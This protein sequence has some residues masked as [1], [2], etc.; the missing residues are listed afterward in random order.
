MAVQEPLKQS[1]A[2][3]DRS[4]RETKASHIVRLLEN[5]VG[6]LDGKDLLEIGTGSGIIASALAKRVRSFLSVDVNDERQVLDFEF[7]R[8]ETERLPNPSE[9]FD[10]VVSNHVI[11]HVDDQQLHLGEVARV[12]RPGGVC[13]LATPNRWRLVEPHF[14]LPFLSW[15]PPRLRDPYVR[16]TR[17]G[18]WFDVQP[19]TWGRI[20]RL[21]GTAGLACTDLA[22]DKVALTL[23]GRVGPLVR[24]ATPLWFLARPLLPTFVVLLSK[25]PV[26]GDGGRPRGG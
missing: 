15:L 3:L 19:L 1:H 20:V 23:G 5:A 2:I 18:E 16:V 11:E 26:R 24:A 21:A 22:R 4:S 6:R 12:L 25:R 10:V 13:Y 8:V 7:Q 17:R 14:R 9:S